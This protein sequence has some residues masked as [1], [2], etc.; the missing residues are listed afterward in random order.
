[1]LQ[2]LEQAKM[3]AAVVLLPEGVPLPDGVASTRMGHKPTV[4]VAPKAFGPPDK[5]T[6]LAELAAHPWAL[7]QDDCGMRSALSRAMSMAGLPFNVAVEAFD[8]ALQLSLV[9]R[10]LGVGLASPE[11]L[12]R[13]PH[14]K[15]LQI[16]D[17][18]EFRSGLNVWLVHGALPSRLARP[19]A[20]VRDTLIEKLA[21]DGAS[22][23]RAPSPRKKRRTS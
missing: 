21:Q 3:D 5:P 12:A 8:S 6:S 18:P 14:A 20:L 7:N 17:V 2:G 22:L 13:S 10:G 9:A 4:V 23:P 19:V 16:L 11:V 1:M 15:S